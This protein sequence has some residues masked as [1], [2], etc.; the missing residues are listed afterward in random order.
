MGRVALEAALCLREH[1][2]RPA[3]HG[4]YPA[5]LACGSPPPGHE[6]PYGRLP[7]FEGLENCNLAWSTDTHT[8][9]NTWQPHV[10][11]APA[12]HGDVNG[13]EAIDGEGRVV[14]RGKRFALVVSPHPGACATARL[15]CGAA[16]CTQVVVGDGPDVARAFP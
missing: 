3:S 11:Y 1:A 7:V 12:A 6:P 5:P 14:A 4:R 15:R 8:W 10:L 9:W 2:A 16:S 13:I